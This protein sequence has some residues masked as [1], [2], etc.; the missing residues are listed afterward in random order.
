MRGTQA[1]AFDDPVPNLGA[2]CPTRNEKMD[3]ESSRLRH[4]EEIIKIE[5]QYGDYLMIA[6][7]STLLL[8]GPGI[9]APE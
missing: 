3:G 7:Q 6:I 5:R 8:R 2:K 1:P 9:E 4:A